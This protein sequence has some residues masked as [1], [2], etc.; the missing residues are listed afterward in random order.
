MVQKDDND[1]KG[2]EAIRD[3]SMRTMGA[4]SNLKR[5]NSALSLTPDPST[6]GESNDENVEPHPEPNK[7]HRKV[8]HNSKSDVNDM[9]ELM[10]LNEERRAQFEGKIV[11]A[12]EESTAVYERTQEKFLNVL[13]AKLN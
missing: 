3:Q 9:K 2:G 12:L 8:K 1:R 4:H 5:R 10:V 11:H 6:D 7:K 13:M